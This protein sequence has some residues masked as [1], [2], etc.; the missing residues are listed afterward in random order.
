MT[1]KDKILKHVERA[2][3]AKKAAINKSKAR[4][5]LAEEL[6]CSEADVIFAETEIKL[7][8]I[9]RFNLISTCATILGL[10]F[11]LYWAITNT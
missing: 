1:E 5:Q 2:A 10:G 11:F 8:W 6:G 9:R 7:A 3:I 4:R